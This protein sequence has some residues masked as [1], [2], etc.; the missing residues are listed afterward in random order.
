M[1]LFFF[2]TLWVFLMFWSRPGAYFEKEI[3][4]LCYQNDIV[5][6]V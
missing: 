5:F 4:F 6:Y 3:T 1:I 2:G